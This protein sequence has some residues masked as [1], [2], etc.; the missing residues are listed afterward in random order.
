MTAS[1]NNLI[2]V[3]MLGRPHGIR[4]EVRVS[5][6]AESLDLLRSGEVYLQA[7]NRPPRKVEVESV[8]IHQGMPLV[9]FAEAPDRTA[10]EI[11]RGQT[12]LVAD[13]VLP[14]PDG[15][16]VYLHDMLGL[17]VVLDA[18]GS[19]LGT[20]EQV[21]FHGEQEVWVIVTPDGREV[22]FPAVP[23]FVPDIDLDAEII[24]IAPP[25]GLLELYLG[26]SVPHD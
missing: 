12:L 22:L 13:A 7:G 15:D 17:S 4:G 24:R 25:E 19:R 11:L 18:D 10:A 6:Y 20:L 3:G 26:Q 23:E 8:R 21:L 14:E 2:E 9:R 16:E 1:L 5:Y